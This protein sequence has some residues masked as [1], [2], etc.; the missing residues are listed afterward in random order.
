MAYC[1]ELSCCGLRIMNTFKIL[2]KLLTSY[3]LEGLLEILS[4]RMWTAK[5][6][7]SNWCP[8]SQNFISRYLHQSEL[9]PISTNTNLTSM[10]TYHLT[11]RSETRAVMSFSCWP[12]TG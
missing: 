12:V 6:Q 11:I 8:Q 1:A 2:I 7:L 5:D 10:S 9:K 4:T 3:F